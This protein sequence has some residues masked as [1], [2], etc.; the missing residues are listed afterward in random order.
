MVSKL[1]KNLDSKNKCIYKYLTAIIARNLT[2]TEEVENR[3]QSE[4]GL[5]GV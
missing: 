4:K 5:S 1:E 3:I 2:I